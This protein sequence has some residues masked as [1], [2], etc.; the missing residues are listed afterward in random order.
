V[1]KFAAWRENPMQ[2]FVKVKVEYEDG[3]RKIAATDVK[4]EQGWL[5]IYDGDKLVGE[6]SRSK[7]ENWSFETD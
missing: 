6:F 3:I 7:V 2:K 1:V 5:R 4:I